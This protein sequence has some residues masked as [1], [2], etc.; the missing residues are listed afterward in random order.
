MEDLLKSLEHHWDN[1]NKLEIVVELATKDVLSV[2]NKNKLKILL[3]IGHVDLTL[4][5]EIAEN[6]LEL[7]HLDLRDAQYSYVIVKY[8]LEEM[9]L[10]CTIYIRAHGSLGW[11]SWRW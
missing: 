6:M 7:E 10:Y 5:K 4:A 8:I 9:N 1:L 11:R 3:L 2:A